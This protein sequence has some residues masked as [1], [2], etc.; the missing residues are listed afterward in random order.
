MR[1]VLLDYDYQKMYN[2]DTSVSAVFFVTYLLVFKIGMLNM[3]IAIIVAHYNQ[4][5][6]DYQSDD[7]VSFFTV[8]QKII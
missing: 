8:V 3:F 1:V 4:F 6:R 2:A 5:R 7:N